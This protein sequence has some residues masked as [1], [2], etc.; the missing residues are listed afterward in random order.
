MHWLALIA[1]MNAAPAT[2]ALDPS[3]MIS[4]GSS[5][6]VGSSS[7]PNHLSVRADEAIV[8]DVAA[9]MREHDTLREF[10]IVPD[11]LV[12]PDQSVGNRI[13][14]DFS[15][16][17]QKKLRVSYSIAVRH[18][19]NNEQCQ[20]LFADLGADGLEMMARTVYVPPPRDLEYRICGWSNLGYTRIGH[21]VTRICDRLANVSDEKSAIILIHEALHHAGL[22]E[23]ATGKNGYS[24]REIN[25]IVKRACGFRPYM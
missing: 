1:L 8:L 24:S 4:E 18:L 12:E 21:R 20:A 22:P 10:D 3:G 11:T 23:D 19:R 16:I 7:S 25:S 15:P 9:P 2:L 14:A 17:L 6:R 5:W 13:S